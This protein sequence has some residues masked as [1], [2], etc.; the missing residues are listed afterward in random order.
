MS[1][2]E[3]ALATKVIGDLTL[4][5]AL[6]IGGAGMSAIGLASSLSAKPPKTTA[7]P[8]VAAP[9]VMPIPDDAVA[10]AAR[11]EPFR[12]RIYATVPRIGRE[13]YAWLGRLFSFNTTATI[14]LGVFSNPASATVPS[15]LRPGI[16]GFSWTRETGLPK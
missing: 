15:R 5:S 9:A 12:P 2:I 7:P 10:V 3:S 11:S 16:I 8:A 6:A 14:H 13:R 1:G 4:G